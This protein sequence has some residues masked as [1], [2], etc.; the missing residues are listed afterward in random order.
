MGTTTR[1]G[2]K[3]GVTESAADELVFAIVIAHLCCNLFQIS[4]PS[5]I[6]ITMGYDHPHTQKDMDIRPMNRSELLTL[7]LVVTNGRIATKIPHILQ[8]QTKYL[9]SKLNSHWN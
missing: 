9:V 3:V 2:L 1:Y 4:H 7:S 8:C 5:A 6:S